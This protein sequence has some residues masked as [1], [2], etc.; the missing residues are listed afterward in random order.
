[1]IVTNFAQINA[2]NLPYYNK[3]SIDADSLCKAKIAKKKTI[4]RAETTLPSS[5]I[6][7]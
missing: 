5:I 7:D 6:T 3:Q 2:R 1:M 4:K